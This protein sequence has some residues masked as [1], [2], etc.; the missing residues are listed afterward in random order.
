MAIGCPSRRIRRARTR[1]VQW[2]S[3]G[4]ELQRG[5]ARD[6]DTQSTKSAVVLE[7]PLELTQGKGRPIGELSEYCGTAQY[8]VYRESHGQDGTR[9]SPTARRIVKSAGAV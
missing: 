6:C 7:A 5:P 9:Y 8:C 1:Q 2:S 4:V 3:G